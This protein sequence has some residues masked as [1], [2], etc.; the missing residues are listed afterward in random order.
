[1]NILRLLSGILL[2]IQV[3]ST[4]SGR[5]EKNIKINL[6]PKVLAGQISWPIGYLRLR[7][8]LVAEREEP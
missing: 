2:L 4:D 1:M 6:S 5:R 8:I 3:Y 7:T